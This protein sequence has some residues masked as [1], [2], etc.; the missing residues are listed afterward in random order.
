M[1]SWL[2]TTMLAA[3]FGR[4]R[5]M[6]SLESGYSILLPTPMDMPFLLRFALEGLQGIDT[7]NCRQILVVPD[8]WGDD[9]GASLRTVIA[10]YKDPRLELVQL[11][12][13]DYAFIRRT[14][15]PGGAITHWMMVVNG[16]H[17]VRCEYAFL[18]DADA[19]FLEAGGLERQ[20]K[21]CLDREMY[22]LGVTARWD[23]FFER[24][25]Y[26][27]P[28]T[29]ELMYSTRWARSRPPYALKGRRLQTP[30]GLAEFDSMLYPQY[31]D[32]PTGKIGVMQEPPRFVHFNGTIFTYRMFRDRKGQS[33]VDELFRILLLAIFEDLVPSAD[34]K[35]VVP[36]V[37][38]LIRGLTADSTAIQYSGESVARNYAEFRSMMELLCQSPIFSGNR[39]KRIRELLAPFD[40]T[41]VGNTLQ[42]E[43]K[44]ENRMRVHGLGA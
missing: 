7:R 34:G 16:T 38:E 40:A 12:W 21:E 36:T 9:D 6:Q 25:G 11:R 32:Y 42:S 17:R 27:I 31:L 13:R 41:F 33:V 28:G 14:K 39:A 15:P 30:H 19:F 2:K 35:R 44:K 37:N 29:W 24:L 1:L 20:F 23:P 4:W 26:Q 3:A 43:L 18:H 10:E 22:S 8:G 5:R